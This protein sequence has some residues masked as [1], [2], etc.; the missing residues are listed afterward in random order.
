MCPR[1]LMVLVNRKGLSTMLKDLP[2][3]E[4]RTGVSLGDYSEVFKVFADAPFFEY[5]APEKIVKSYHDFD[6]EDAV[7]FGYY[8]GNECAGILALRP[9]VPGQFPV[10]YPA[11][12]KVMYFSDI[13]TLPQY[14]G[15]GIGTHLMLHG[16]RHIKVLGYEY[17]YLRTNEKGTSMS[18]GI[19][20]KC[21]FKQIWGI[22]QE[23]DFPRTKPYIPTTDLRIFM[24]KA[25]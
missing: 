4:I 14:R 12:A 5:W 20:E 22:C 9:H 1:Y 2:P 10:T 13:A 25:L 21:G 8:I 19:A 18:Y 24:E 16:L 17:A 3:G 7:I 6:A 11:D 23:V 15:M